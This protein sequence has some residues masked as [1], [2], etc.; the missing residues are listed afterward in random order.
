MRGQGARSRSGSATHSVSAPRHGAP[1]GRPERN[2]GKRKD[3]R[4][5]KARGSKPSYEGMGGCEE[6]GSTHS[7]ATTPNLVCRRVD[8]SRG[9]EGARC[10]Y[11]FLARSA[12]CL[13]SP[14]PPPSI[15]ALV[16]ER[17]CDGAGAWEYTLPGVQPRKRI[18]GTGLSASMATFRCSR[19]SDS[20]ERNLHGAGAGAGAGLSFGRRQKKDPRRTKR[21]GLNRATRRWG[22]GEEL[23]SPSA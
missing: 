11:G 14:P 23:G 1:T 18:G 19:G 21:R 12:Q 20:A 10:Q 7:L 2:S 4:R 17:Y 16:V 6:L 13:P 22:A 9:S 8:T 3:P 5:N 15:R